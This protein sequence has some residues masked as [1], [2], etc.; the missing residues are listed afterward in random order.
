M[1]Q[2]SQFLEGLIKAGSL[3]GRLCVCVYVCVCAC[4]CVGVCVGQMLSS[5]E[6][7]PKG[8]THKRE[9]NWHRAHPALLPWSCRKCSKMSL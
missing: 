2:V 6:P 7:P 4:M 5:L 1:L 8:V 3:L 9:L